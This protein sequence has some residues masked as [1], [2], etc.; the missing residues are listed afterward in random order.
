MCLEQLILAILGTHSCTTLLRKP[1]VTP[2]NNLLVHLLWASNI[3][4]L[5]MLFHRQS[6]RRDQDP[7]CAKPRLVIKCC[8]QGQLAL[9]KYDLCSNMIHRSSSSPN[10]FQKGSKTLIM[11]DTLLFKPAMLV[12]K[13]EYMIK[14]SFRL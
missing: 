5:L 11:V 13:K 7:T 8:Q 10:S 2:M 14:F 3:T 6:K 4:T 9:S 12:E 1:E